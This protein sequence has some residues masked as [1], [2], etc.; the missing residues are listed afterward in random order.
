MECPGLGAGEWGRGV[1]PQAR[2]KRREQGGVLG[3]FGIVWRGEKGINFEILYQNWL[4]SPGARFGSGPSFAREAEKSRC[5]V[6]G[7]YAHA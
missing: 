6:A 5:V 3:S 4:F 7:A 2:S 1:A